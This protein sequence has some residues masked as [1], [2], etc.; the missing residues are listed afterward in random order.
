[1]KT[2]VK[3]TKLLFIGMALSL[4]FLILPDIAHAKETEFEFYYQNIE[5]IVQINEPEPEGWWE[6][7]KSFIKKGVN[8]VKKTWEKTVTR[9]YF[10]GSGIKTW[11]S[12]EDS[13]I[14]YK[15]RRTKVKSEAHLLELMGA[16]S[17]NDLTDGQKSLLAVYRHSKSEAIK[18]RMAYGYQ[19]KLRVMLSDTTGFDNANDYPH[20][21]RDFWPYSHGNLIQMSSGRYN[22]PG[23]ESDSRSTFVHEYAHSMD[24][25]IKEFIHPYGKD[26]LHYV[27]ELSKPRAAFVEGWA[28]FN[29]MLDSEDEADYMQRTINRI[30]IESKSEKGEYTYYDA[31]SPEIS[32]KDLLSVEGI[33]ANI[34][35]RIS[36]EI[37]DGREKV[38]ETFTSTR[39]KLFRNL[40]SFSRAFARKY[41]ED[42][43]KLTEIFDNETHGK[44]SQQELMH[45][46]GDSDAVKDY[47][48]QRE[49]PAETSNPDASSDAQNVTAQAPA[50]KFLDAARMS[51]QD[52]ATNMQQAHQNVKQA[53]QNYKNAVMN[54]APA[55]KCHQ[56][57]TELRKH[58]TRLKQLLD[59]RNK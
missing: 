27:N 54:Q 53:L 41:P 12:R 50:R 36:T 57:Q 21:R 26:D 28:E 10:P 3:L 34:L 8:A 25:T 35:Y 2:S 19:S 44:L 14:A 16:E 40:K 56:L 45:Y 32:G 9:R 43:A 17:E 1:M 11:Y 18:E 6:H 46:A 30:K 13:N 42:A 31:D 48:A 15:V 24:R 22:Y 4:L 39:W 20:V 47:I 23:S 52:F 59:S 7:A 33:N 51:A 37:P 5:E 49:E 29:E 55:T 38:F 58:Q